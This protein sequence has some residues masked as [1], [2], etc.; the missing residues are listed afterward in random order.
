MMNLCL[1]R[2]KKSSYSVNG[3]VASAINKAF[4]TLGQ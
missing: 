2:M 1:K 4:S 3:A